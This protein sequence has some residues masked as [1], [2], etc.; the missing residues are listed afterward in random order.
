MR[1]L[2]FCLLVIIAWKQS[3]CQEHK[4]DSLIN[5]LNNSDIGF[6]G[7]YFGSTI[8]LRGNVQIAIFNIGKA[9][10]GK[11]A[12]ILE[13]STKGIIAHILLSWIWNKDERPKTI[14]IEKDR[15]VVYQYNDLYFFLNGYN[16]EVYANK[17]DLELNKLKWQY[18]LKKNS[19]EH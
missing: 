13:D 4:I 6:N 12:E 18:F 7:D 3:N 2:F 8:D 5:L 16:K 9:A 19:G 11:L 15:I 14:Y 10:S 1:K 17:Y